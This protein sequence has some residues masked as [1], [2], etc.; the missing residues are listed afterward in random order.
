MGDGWFLSAGRGPSIPVTPDP[1]LLVPQMDDD[2][3]IS[4]SDGHESEEQ[5]Q[6]ESDEQ[7]V[8]HSS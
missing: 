3:V 6:L 1:L 7:L 4:S 8:N 2:G 5:D